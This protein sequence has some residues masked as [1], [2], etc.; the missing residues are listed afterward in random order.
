MA[1]ADLITALDGVSTAALALGTGLTPHQYNTLLAG[2]LMGQLSIPIL[3]LSA[4]ISA[5]FVYNTIPNTQGQYSIYIPAAYLVASSGGPYTLTLSTGVAG[6]TTVLVPICNTGDT[7]L[8]GNLLFNVY[9]DALGNVTSDAWTVSGSN[10]NGTYIKFSDGTMEQWGN[11]G[12]AVV[13]QTI[14]GLPCAY[15]QFD[16]IQASYIP[17]NSY[18]ETHCIWR[19]GLSQFTYAASQPNA[20]W[21]WASKG[22]WR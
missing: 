1:L 5:N 19:Q 4:A 20:A 16:T 7:L 22:R 12:P 3:P 2:A 8:S 11:F 15:T 10:S 17:T 6:K 18:D 14:R 21:Y 13:G 9:V